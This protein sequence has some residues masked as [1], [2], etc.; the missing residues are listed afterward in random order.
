MI[1]KLENYCRSIFHS[2]FQ[3]HNGKDRKNGSRIFK[4]QYFSLSL[5]HSLSRMNYLKA[6]CVDDNKAKHKRYETRDRPGDEMSWEKLCSMRFN[7]VNLYFL[8]TILTINFLK[9]ILS[10]KKRGVFFFFFCGFLQYFECFNVTVV[11]GTFSFFFENL[12]FHIFWHQNWFNF[13]VYIK[14]MIFFV[15]FN[16]FSEINL[17][18]IKSYSPIKVS[19]TLASQF[20]FPT[21]TN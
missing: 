6:F 7:D 12:K 21:D 1:F 3:Y 10:I 14:K 2:W 19:N 18:L 11:G 15:I 4:G 9:T 5:A 13:Q 17:I 20:S 16:S 8:Y